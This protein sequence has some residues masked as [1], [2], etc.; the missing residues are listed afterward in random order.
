MARVIESG[1]LKGAGVLEVLEREVAADQGYAGAVA[2]PSGGQAVHLLLRAMFPRGGAAVGLP[3]YLCRSVYDGAA[4]AG[5][6]PVLFDVDP[7]TL[8]ID[9]AAVESAA[10]ALDAVIVPHMFGI[11]A[12]VARFV[13]AGLTVIEDCAQRLKT[14]QP[15]QRADK[16]PFQI[17]SFEATK[18]VA[19]GEGGMLL[20]DDPAVLARAR[21]LRDAPYTFAEP[22]IGPRPTELQ[23]ALAT[24][25][26][27]RLPEFL[28][29]RR[30]IAGRYLQGLDNL[31]A[32]AV[33]P[34]MRNQSTFHYRFVLDVDD[35]PA[36][37][38]AAAERSVAF[39]RPVA[40][41]G[42][43]TLFSVSGS[44]PETERALQRL[45]SIPLYPKLTDVEADTT[46][47]LTKDLLTSRT[48]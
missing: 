19:A 1:Q 28:E 13:A 10:R 40:P 42:L 5:C 20:A 41:C 8:S 34:P 12:P 11:E 6:R 32:G 2:T 7:M 29:R 33:F 25:Q 44:F 46:L 24:V 14:P 30:Q 23:A 47:Q 39:R 17:L 22:A 36:M 16:P 4:Q 3:D 38:A 15:W 35:P 27:R 45:V 9:P 26:W 18:L 43:H 21:N 37:I 31:F 48:R